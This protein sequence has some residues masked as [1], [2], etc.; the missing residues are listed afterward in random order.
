MALLLSTAHTHCK[1]SLRHVKQNIKEII[2]VHHL[3]IAIFNLPVLMIV[4]PFQCI[5]P[6]Q[7]NYSLELQKKALEV[8]QILQTQYVHVVL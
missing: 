8:I 4:S 2:T 6:W 7:P 5:F 3:G 1:A